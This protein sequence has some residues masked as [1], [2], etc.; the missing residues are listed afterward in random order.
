MIARRRREA[1]TSTKNQVV[2]RLRALADAVDGDTAMFYP[3]LDELVKHMAG[4]E[5]VLA[6][7]ARRPDAQKPRAPSAGS[8]IPTK[9]KLRKGQVTRNLST[10]EGREFWDGCEHSAIACDSWTDA[11]RAW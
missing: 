2:Q 6:A 3:D 10:P 11:E 7:A 9:D 4:I 8:Q 5:R 1:T